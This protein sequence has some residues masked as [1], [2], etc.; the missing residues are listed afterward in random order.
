M[1]P[2]FL[3]MCLLSVT[4]G[5]ADLRVSRSRAT[6]GAGRNRP[7]D[8]AS[9]SR[10]SGVD[11][12]LEIGVQSRRIS[13]CEVAQRDWLLQEPESG[14]SSSSRDGGPCGAPESWATR[15]IQG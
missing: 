2:H 5:N 12:V 11:G 7:Q 14:G 1:S 8:V 10:S 3:F 4:P 6:P 15:S 13:A 9:A